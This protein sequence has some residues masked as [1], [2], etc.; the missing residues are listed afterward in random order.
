[1]AK[2][3]KKK[4][5]CSMAAAALLIALCFSWVLVSVDAA[6]E[7][8][9]QLRF[10]KDG[11]FKILQVADMH[12]GDGKSTLCL[13]VLPSQIPGCSDLN[14]SAFIHRMIEAEKPHL[15]VFTGIFF[16]V[17]FCCSPSVFVKLMIHLFAKLTSRVNFR[18]P[19]IFP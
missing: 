10:S 17:L 13:D 7:Q 2:P 19:K 9:N 8:R 4:Q 14:T 1:M 11:H 5:C 16:N 3:W 18:L 6:S 15:I 12:F